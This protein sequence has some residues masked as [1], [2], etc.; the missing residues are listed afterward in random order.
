MSKAAT[1][2][3]NESLLNFLT[4]SSELSQNQKQP[5]SNPIRVHISPNWFDVIQSAVH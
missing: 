3:R 1:M 4:Q 5:Y 2:S